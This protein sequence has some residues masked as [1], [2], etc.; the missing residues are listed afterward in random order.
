MEEKYE[1]CLACHEPILAG[2]FH[3]CERPE[4][5]TDPDCPVGATI[6]GW[7]HPIEEGCSCFSDEGPTGCADDNDALGRALRGMSHQ[8]LNR[9]LSKSLK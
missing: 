2:E 3:P 1:Q 4:N 6:I 8:D 9:A 5:C 7:P